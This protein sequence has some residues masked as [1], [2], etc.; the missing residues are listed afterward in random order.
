MRRTSSR[1]SVSPRCCDPLSTSLYMKTTPAVVRA[2]L[3]PFINCKH[4]NSQN[5]EVIATKQQHPRRQIHFHLC[6]CSFMH[7]FKLTVEEWLGSRRTRSDPGKTEKTSKYQITD[8]QLLE[9]PVFVSLSLS[10]CYLNRHTQ[11]V[12]THD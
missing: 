7:E 9:P 1:W 4:L 8:N 2:P 5:A 6:V 3:I 12:V 10:T 11:A